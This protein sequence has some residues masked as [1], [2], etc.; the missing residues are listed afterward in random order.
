MSKNKK[1]SWLGGATFA[2]IALVFG[3]YNIAH[4]VGSGSFNIG[5]ILKQGSV[6][7]ERTGSSYKTAAQKPEG[8]FTTGQ[9][10]DIALSA[11]GFNDSGGALLFNH[12]GNIASDGENLILADRNNNRVLIWNKAPTGNEYPDIVIGQ[13]DFNSI[14]PGNGLNELNWPVCVATDGIRLIVCDTQNHRVLVWNAMPA[15]NGESADMVF[16]GFGDVSADRRG[17]IAWPWAAWTNGEKFIITSTSG[18]QVL[19]WSSFPTKSQQIADIA[20][21][22]PQF[23]TPRSIGSDGKSLAIADHNARVGGSETDIQGTFFWREFPTQENRPYD[24]FIAMP[25][26]EDPPANKSLAQGEILWGMNFLTDGSF[27]GIGSNLYIWD[28]FPQSASDFADKS[29]GSDRGRDGYWFRGGDGSGT[30]FAHGKLYVSLTNSNKIVG[31]NNLPQKQSE[32]PDFAVGSPGINANT[33]E[34]EFIISNPIP[35]TDGKSLYVLSDFDGML[36]IWKSL[37]D[38]SGSHPDIV[39]RDIQGNDVALFQNTLA[40]A[41]GKELYIWNELP[42]DG[43]QPD[44]RVRSSLGSIRFQD[45]RGVARDDKYFY[46]ADKDADA[47]YVW[48]GAPDGTREPIAKLPIDQ[49]GKLASDGVFLGASCCQNAPGGG[50]ALWRVTDIAASGSKARAY[51]LGWFDNFH[52][53]LPGSALP[54]NGSLFVADNGGNRVLIWND[55]EDAIKLKEPDVILGKKNLIDTTQA[56]GRDSLFMP[57]ALAFDGSFLWVGE[58][59][60]SERLLRFSVR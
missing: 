23:G 15:K 21:Q 60:F 17:R 4:R 32:K 51:H 59:K 37:P 45:I 39:Y 18:R 33:L 36:Y 46:I 56:I 7:V 28:S 48:E 20:I 6:V 10:A 50:I 47:I 55:A 1:A 31:Y 14:A 30:A 42:K 16:G 54:Y 11:I 57:N 26:G 38:E 35:A 29:I 8:W 2:V 44:T 13:K 9:N 40:I 27:I 34:T 52:L 58:V 5:Y 22:L 53:N 41:G 3:V 19:I 43:E 12:Q 49:P 25:S 24:F